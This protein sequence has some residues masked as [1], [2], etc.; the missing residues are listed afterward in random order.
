M[1]NITRREV[2]Y[3]FRYGLLTYKVNFDC[4]YVEIKVKNKKK[5]K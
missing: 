2:V 4:I 1:I 5:A 3:E